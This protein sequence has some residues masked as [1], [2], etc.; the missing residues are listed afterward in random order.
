M[1]FP[2][3]PELTPNQL[4]QR[5]LALWKE[6]KL[7]QQVMDARREAPSFVF[8]E[9]PPTA[10]GRPGI[11]HV[12]SRT[13]KDLVCRFHSMQG[14]S[15]TRI[16]GWDTHGL[17]VEIEVEKELKLSGKKDIERF[18]VEEFNAR[19][20]K[21]VFKY[22][23]EWESLSDRIGYW[24]DYDHP[25]VT[26][27]NPYVESVWW[28][29]QRLHQRNLLYRGHRVLPYCPR[30]GTVL[31]SHELALGY[32][33]VTT[34]SVYVTFPLDADPGRQLL[35]WTTTPWTLLSNVA[36]AVHPELE[37]G[38]YQ[39]GDRRL[40]LATSRASL[41]S[42]SQRGAPTF[43]ELGPVRTFRGGDLVGERYRR[44]LEVVA[45]PEDQKSRLVVAADFVSADDGSGL[46]HLV[47]AFGADDFEAGLEQGLALV[48]PVTPDGTFSG[49]SWPEIEGRLVTARET[50][51]LIIQRLKQDGRWHS[52]QPYTHT[53]PHCWRCSSPLIYYARDSWFVRTSAVK[54]RMLELNRQVSWHP[55]EVGAGRFGEWLENNVDWAL[56]RDRYWGTPLPVWACDRDPAHVEVIGSYAQLAERWGQP[57]PAD[58]DP[59]KPFIDRYSWIC[60]CGGTMRRTPE[61]IDTWFDSGAMPY[62]Q[63][64]YPFEHDAEF[65]EHFPA[66]FIC[67]GVDQTRGWF[68]SLLAIATTAFDS[69]AYRHVV[70]NELVLDAEGQK[71]SKSKG[72]VVDPWAMIEQFG[73][74]TIR[75]YLLASS[76]VW[77]PKRFDPRTIPEVAGKFFNALRNSYTFFAGYAGAWSPSQTPSLGERPLVDRWLRSRLDATV[78][79]VSQA[80]MRYDV[81]AGVRAI[82]DFVVDDLSQWYV[83]VNRARFWAPDA[84]ADPAALATLHE[85][86]STVARLLAPAAP[87]A[88]DWL[89][90]A[91]TGTSVHLAPFPVPLAQQAPEF[92]AAMDAVRRLASLARS[93]REERNIRVRQ[94]L[95]R[96]QVAVP[97]GIR[98]PTLE[99]LLELLR[100]EVNVKDIEVVTSDTDLVRLRP[101]PNY[102]TL[103]KRYGKRTPTVAAAAATL[104]AVQLR[105][106]EAGSPATLNLDGEPVTFLPEDVAVEREVAT[107]W[108][109][110]S[111]GA[112]VAALDPRLNDELRREGLA[113]EVVNRVQRIRKEA[114]YAYTDRIALWIDGDGPVVDA[115]R[116]HASFIVGETLARGLEVGARAPAPDLEHRVD[117]DGH[118]AVVGVQR[119]RDGRASAAPQ[120]TD[121]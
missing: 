118:G 96:M 12:F 45:L 15:V 20:R 102:R 111:N 88:S 29:L 14:E 38:E 32:E 48:R 98:G 49:T 108:L 116:A 1:S 104:S 36:V 66:D 40:I 71:M 117:V 101:K 43:N 97:P 120:P 3:W 46:V 22:Q 11:H 106:L 109:V 30:C 6:E 52:T 91:L 80:W 53:Y 41:P 63:W 34:N 68:Y 28:L 76:Q 23:A 69:L 77:L 87:F 18:G 86:L 51:D 92:D 70:V 78:E 17:P 90:R 65:T 59:H 75:L 58:F 62:A 82:M 24:L 99:Q 107:D 115:V 16:A 21:S 85:A 93:A 64:H 10:N 8:Y 2:S 56:S 47:P 73:A 4:E 60:R 50:N 57:L 9:G 119:Y 54:D 44:P 81:T 114:G 37:Y 7:F 42:S 26:C 5:Q 113:R 89:H 72:N 27:S 110:Q 103:G 95:G 33:T 39:V 94:P 100:L 61:V 13:I 55:P 19:A 112:F 83:R 105:E 79:S 31:S 25:Y 67:E 121:E 84:D 35:V 74:D